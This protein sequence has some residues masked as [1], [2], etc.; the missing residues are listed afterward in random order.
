MKYIR[1]MKLNTCISF[2]IFKEQILR[3][4]D[5]TYR[6]CSGVKDPEVRARSNN[7]RVLLAS[8]R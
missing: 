5:V 7:T 3:S 2:H 6:D 4:Y 1:Q 8:L